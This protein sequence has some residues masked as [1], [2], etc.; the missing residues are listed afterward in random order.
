MV[1]WESVC[2]PENQKVSIR[3]GRP[4]LGGGKKRYPN[5]GIIVG[6]THTHTMIFRSP[7]KKTLTWNATISRRICQI[8]EIVAIAF[9]ANEV[10]YALTIIVTV[11][12]LVRARTAH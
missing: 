9:S 11:A 3:E 5:P 7:I 10:F 12:L 6:H 1:V 4:T 8:P 2:L